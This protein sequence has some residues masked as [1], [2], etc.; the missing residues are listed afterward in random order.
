MEALEIEWDRNQSRW[1]DAFCE[2]ERYKE[3]FGN[4]DVPPKY[5]TEQGFS[6]G[7]WINAQRIQYK[8]GKLA[9]DRIQKLEALGISWSRYER[10]WEI[11]FE[12]AKRYLQTHDDIPVSCITESGYH[13]GQWVV[14]QRK[15]YVAKKLDQ[16]KVELLRALKLLD[17]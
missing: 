12:E 2:A 13:L 4:I 6:L 1:D 7:S 5:Q 16:K 11:G 15:N 9:E 3:K 17:M 14:K 10:L 8:A